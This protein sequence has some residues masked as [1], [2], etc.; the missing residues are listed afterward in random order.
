MDMVAYL[1]GVSRPAA[2]YYFSPNGNSRNRVS[3]RVA[4]R[5]REAANQIGY[6]PYM[7]DEWFERFGRHLVNA[8]RHRGASASV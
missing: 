4:A 7:N 1:A 5:L 8:E 2:S 3:K 6:E